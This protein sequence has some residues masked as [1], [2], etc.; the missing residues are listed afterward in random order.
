M[1]KYLVGVLLICFIGWSDAVC[2]TMCSARR[3]TVD[4]TF[5]YSYN[6][7]NNWTTTN[8]SSAVSEHEII[9]RRRCACTCPAN[10]YQP[11]SNFCHCGKLFYINFLNCILFFLFVCY[12]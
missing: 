6:G 4:G 5:E 12:L 2:C 9:D 10:H 8:L 11:D 3:R 1:Q 7:L